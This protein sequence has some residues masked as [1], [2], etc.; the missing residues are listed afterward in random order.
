MIETIASGLVLAMV[1]GLTFIAYKHPAG[2][3][4]LFFPIAN[5]ISS[6]A[7]GLCARAL[8]EIAF[9]ASI[10]SHLAKDFPTRPMSDIAQNAS[11]VVDSLKSF[12]FV[13]TIY[14]VVMAYLFFLRQL[15]KILDS[16][17]PGA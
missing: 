2:F 13:V 8:L 14:L 4:R 11:T 12:G 15:P 1:S 17:T 7:I 16:T 10:I 5:V 9:A 3:G 6:V